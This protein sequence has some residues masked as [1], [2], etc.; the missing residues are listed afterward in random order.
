MLN[1]RTRQIFRDYIDTMSAFKFRLNRRTLENSES[2]EDCKALSDKIESYTQDFLEEIEFQLERSSDVATQKSC[3]YY[4]RRAG[5]KT[6]KITE[7]I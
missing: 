1:K 5:Q 7:T 4:L 2:E 6:R 3:N